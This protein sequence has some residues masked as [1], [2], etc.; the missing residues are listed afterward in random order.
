MRRLPV[1]VAVLFA[2]AGCSSAGTSDA[3]GTSPA[4]SAKVSAPASPS[5]ASSS[6]GRAQALGEYDARRDAQA[7]IEAALALAK[8]DGRNVLI[9][10]GADWCLDCRVLTKLSRTGTVAGLLRDGYHV[11]S[12]DVGEFDRNLDVAEAYQV[13]LQ[14]SGI[15]AL[16]VLDPRG[17]V[18]VATNDGSFAT[19]RS[20]DAGDVAAFLRRW[21]PAA[22]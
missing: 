22:R 15:P 12:V 14:R 3:A 1:L 13:D 10:F 6:T 17:T 11:V 21:Y 9:D 5:S 18:K 16:V 20:M 8:Q 19:A 4:A 7:D 2:V